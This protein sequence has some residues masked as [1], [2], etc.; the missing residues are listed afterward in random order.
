MTSQA[1][2]Q[3][4]TIHILRK[5]SRSKGNQT[6]KFGQLVDYNKKNHAEMSQGD[7]FQTSF[8]FYKLL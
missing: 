5:I 8:D 2:Q 7:Q 4:I 3:T 6:I 1:G